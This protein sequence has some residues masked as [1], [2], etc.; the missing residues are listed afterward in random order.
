M[1][2]GIFFVSSDS[3]ILGYMEKYIKSIEKVYTRT[4]SYRRVNKKLIEAYLEKPEVE[5]RNSILL[6]NFWLINYLADKI[7]SRNDL[8]ESLKPDILGDGAV[9]FL[10]VLDDVVRNN[11]PEFFSRKMYRL[12]QN[13]LLK[14]YVRDKESLEF[15]G[16]L[17]YLPVAEINLTKEMDLEDFWTDLNEIRKVVVWSRLWSRTEQRYIPSTIG[18]PERSWFLLTKFLEGIQSHEELG[19]ITRLSKER[20]R[21]LI[22]KT[23]HKLR[24]TPEIEVLRKYL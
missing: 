10:E 9:H 8:P 20:V 13:H 16:D 6:Q 23:I 3:L 5:I 7:I 18:I 22:E 4:N 11:R 1:G 2:V 15:S 12:L 17:D 14:V 24:E 21:Q 19:W